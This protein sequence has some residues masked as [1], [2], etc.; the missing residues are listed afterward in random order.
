MWYKQKA[1]QAALLAGLL[2]IVGVL[3]TLNTQKSSVR[4]TP[5]NATFQREP[6]TI[7]SHG[8]YA[9]QTLDDLIKK[10][11]LI[12]IGKVATINPARWNTADG[13][14]SPD[15]TIENITA[16]SIIYTDL[17]FAPSAILQGA[18]LKEPLVIRTF[19]GQVEQDIM[20]VDSSGRLVPD[21]EYLLFLQKD[22]LGSTAK[23]E[24]E[25]YLP[26]GGLQ[27][28][29]EVQGERVVAQAVILGEEQRTDP[30]QPKDEA[31]LEG[32]LLEN[33]LKQIEQSK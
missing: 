25:H 9:T 18:E 10:S 6:I 1:V 19:G 2:I 33:L 21:Q 24:P 16:S 31:G 3:L 15:I 28:V 12:V 32:L 7:S 27:G 17:T 29:Y 5:E 14:L 26:F 20:I 23:V 22:T 30:T 8:I 4:A 13:T 11:D